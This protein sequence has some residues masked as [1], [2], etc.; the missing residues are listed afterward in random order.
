MK[1]CLRSVFFMACLYLTCVQ[2][3]SAENSPLDQIPKGW[4][5]K[6]AYL[7]LVVNKVAGD[8]SI[9]TSPTIVMY[10]NWDEIHV[11]E[12]AKSGRGVNSF[13]NGQALRISINTDNKHYH[14]YS[15]LLD[16]IVAQHGS[17]IWKY[18]AQQNVLF[19]IQKNLANDKRWLLNSDLGSNGERDLT[20][21]A[22]V[23][24]LVKM[25][26]LYLM[27]NEKFLD[28][29]GDP[30]VIVWRPS[31]HKEKTARSLVASMIR[32]TGT[33]LAHLYYFR[34]NPNHD[35]RTGFDGLKSRDVLHWVDNTTDLIDNFD[36]EKAIDLGNI[37]TKSELQKKGQWKE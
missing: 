17:V 25:H 22:A 29:L 33:S 16:D 1:T 21:Q 30:N 18:D 12:P 14:K 37:L 23:E 15:E 8:L 19:F 27:T 5:I 34:C 13:T 28:Y 26:G 10:E 31:E 4:N 6:G 36:I 3:C 9:T 24:L 11:M 7:Q 20:F 2:I 35:P 32:K